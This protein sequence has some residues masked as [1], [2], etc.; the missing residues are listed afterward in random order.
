MPYKKEDLLPFCS[1]ERYPID[2]PLAVWNYRGDG[3]RQGDE[4]LRA[5]TPAEYRDQ[6]HWDTVA[7]DGRVLIRLPKTKLRRCRDHS[8]STGP[9]LSS[10]YPAFALIESAEEREFLPP[11]EFGKARYQFVGDPSLNGATFSDAM[12]AYERDPDSEDFAPDPGT[13]NLVPE[14]VGEQIPFLGRWIN[15]YYLR[16]LT[17]CLPGV[18]FLAHVEEPGEMFKFRFDG[19]G[20]LLMPMRAPA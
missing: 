7:T 16:K 5:R 10:V 20:G 8:I 4:R 13:H 1:G 14:E 19:G 9:N 12:A 11:P 2:E 17:R 6:I 15:S 18:R 3:T